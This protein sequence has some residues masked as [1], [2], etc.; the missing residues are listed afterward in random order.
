[1]TTVAAF[2]LAL[3]LLIIVHEFGHYL[4][5]RWCNVKVLRFSIGFGPVIARRRSGRD[6]TE[7]AL[8]A[9]PLGGYV[10][11]LDEREGEVAPHELARAFNR[12]S[13]ARR[14][15]I[16]LAGPVANL[17][18]AIALYWITF[19]HGVP[20]IK[21]VIGEIAAHSA[22]AEA[23]FQAGEVIDSIKGAKTET[24]QDA[25]WVLLQQAMSR[26]PI[27]FE[28]HTARGDYARRQLVTAGLKSEQLDADF[29]QALGFL[30]SAQP[31]PALLGELSSE[32][33]AAR[34]GLHSGDRVIAVDGR[35][36]T[37]WNE[38]VD[39]IRGHPALPL[40][41]EIERAAGGEARVKVTPEAITEGG[42]T[43]GR[44]G[45]MNP[46]LVDVRYAPLPALRLAA[47]RTW[48]TS[49]FSLRMLGKMVIGEVSL[50]NLS[51]PI[52]IADY[53][54]QSAQIGWIAYT[55]FLALISISLGVLN[56]LPI[57]L[58]DGGH[59]MYYMLEIIK[60]SPVSEH[61]MEIG[62]RIGMGVLLLLMA[63]AVYNDIS[64]L[65]NG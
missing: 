62:Q 4:V 54:G 61:V 55:T 49:A 37:S 17:L 10:K 35:A 32:G 8:S 48:E 43:I 26:Q 12:Q 57:P 14:C 7:W 9:V 15:A 40:E 22:A 39:V 58:L 11:M 51:G 33:A 28:V 41:F 65:I 45:I 60:G 5:A 6:Q 3:G 36:V 1:M 2:V 20:G 21:P 46:Y 29:L 63:C 53:A 24:W 44:A 47:A 23:G 42:K 25:R 34:A 31:P 16:V 64:R 38:L 56:L 13:V 27:E 59:L 19:M 30:R 52:T 18:L 50:K